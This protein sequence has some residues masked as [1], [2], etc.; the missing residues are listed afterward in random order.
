MQGWFNV[1]KS[2]NVTHHTN[3]TK[4]KKS[5]DHLNRSR[6]IP[7]YLR[8]KLNKDLVL[9]EVG[10]IAETKNGLEESI[11]EKE[12]QEILERMIFLTSWFQY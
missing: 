12:F 2:V 9:I 10:R 3:K 5:H 6:K 1:H 11:F 4:D 7:I 8:K